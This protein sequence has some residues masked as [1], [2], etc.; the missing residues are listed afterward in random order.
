MIDVSEKLM[1]PNWIGAIAGVI[2]I[3][4]AIW[5]TTGPWFARRWREW[6]ERR[7]SGYGFAYRSRYTKAGFCE[8][9]EGLDPNWIAAIATIVGIVVAILLGLAALKSISLVLTIMGII[10]I[11][12]TPIV[13]FVYW[14]LRPKIK[15][16]HLATT[17]FLPQPTGRIFVEIHGDG[18][19]HEQALEIDGKARISPRPGSATPGIGAQSRTLQD[20]LDTILNPRPENPELFDA[21]FQSD[22][23]EYLLKTIFPDLATKPLPPHTEVFVHTGE[24]G[25][26]LLPWHVL[27]QGNLFLCAQEGTVSLSGLPV[28]SPPGKPD[29]RAVPFAG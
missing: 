9:F 19:A 20:I 26:L 7:T 29:A 2:S 1:D 10:I 5:A 12:L 6:K 23:G 15:K 11:V 16:Q 14:K 18:V 13:F 22:V 28:R 4:V 25:L 17:K 3:I 27:S 21:A 24:P 8:I